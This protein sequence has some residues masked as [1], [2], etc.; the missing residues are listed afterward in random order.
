[1]NVL[2]I[3]AHPDDETLGCGG[4]MLRHV[5][6]GHSV[7]WLIATRADEARYGLRSSIKAAE[8]DAVAQAYPIE[9]VH[10]LNHPA[11]QLDRVPRQELVSE[12]A[13]V[14][15]SVRPEV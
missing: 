7:H 15:N 5:G 13:A 14:A 1:M 3:A 9:E 8:I 6:S 10:R 12:V 4:T 2:V 11:S